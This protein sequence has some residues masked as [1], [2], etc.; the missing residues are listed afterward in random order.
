MTRWLLITSAL[1]AVSPVSAKHLNPNDVAALPSSAPTKT[2]AY[3]PDPLEVGDLRLPGG[4]GPFPVAIIIHGGCFTKGFATTSYMAP[5][6]S[7]LTHNGIATWNVEYRQLGDTGGG[8]PGTYQ[9]WAAAADHLRELA[10]SYPLNLKRVIAV[11]HSAGATAAFWVAARSSLPAASEVRGTAP[12]GVIAAVAIDGPLDLAPWIGPDAE[13]CGQPVVTPLLGG[14]PQEVPSHYAQGSPIALLPFKAQQY[15]VV[16]AVLDSKSAA[17]YT[18]R[19]MAVGD[20]AH[21]LTLT[22]AGH[23]DMLA[24]GTPSWLPVEKIILESLGIKRRN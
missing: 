23:F 18:A 22:D 8:W 7:A 2:E 6:A 21:V 11:G 19:A 17:D 3:G 9:D 20:T 16:S 15:L 13:I 14:T 10:K 1:L 24:P 5:L 12:I 4:P